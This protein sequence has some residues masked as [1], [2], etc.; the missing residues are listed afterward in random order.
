[1]SDS[2][3]AVFFDEK[4]LRNPDPWNF[5][6]SE[7]EQ[8]RYGVILSELGERLYARAFEPGCSVGVLTALLACRCKSLKAMDIS[9]KAVELAQQRCRHLPHV[10]VICG[11]LR[12]EIPAGMFD[13]I[14]FSEIGYYF[15]EEELVGLA[16]ALV[17]QLEKGGTLLA[18]HW[19]GSSKDHL[20]SGDCVHRILPSASGLRLVHQKQYEAFRIDRSERT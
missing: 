2:T 18:V 19:L 6:K 7:Y 1:M 3:S 12:T 17:K 14:V 4:Y 13:L 20:L 9:P 10:D 16:E 5:E 11:S 15:T 8:G